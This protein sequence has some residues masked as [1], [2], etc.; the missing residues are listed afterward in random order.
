LDGYLGLVTEPAR[1]SAIQDSR[2]PLDAGAIAGQLRIRGSWSIRTV[3]ETGSTNDDLAA[4]AGAGRPSNQVLIAELQRTGKGRRG[5]VWTAPP[6]AGLTMSVLLDLPEVPLV[7]RSWIG[8]IGGLCLVRAVA[9]VTGL[10][11][12]LKWPNDLLVAGRK[13]AG[14]LAEA[15]TAGVIL[16][17]GL[18]VSLDATELPR[19]DATS[20]LL[21]GAHTLDRT[22]LAAAVLDELTGWLSRWRAAFGDPERCGLLPAYRAVCATI[23]EEVR[24]ELPSGEH[25]VGTAVDIA[26]D[27]ALVVQSVTGRRSFAAADVHHLRPAR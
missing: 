25:V 21:A 12:A 14:M 4:V 15:T 20:L 17:I 27:G 5:R 22:A 1:A 2:R 10:A 6:G 8:A 3:P 7:R 16:G 19:A 24:V 26:V 18:N 11:A 9:S 13:C 23:G